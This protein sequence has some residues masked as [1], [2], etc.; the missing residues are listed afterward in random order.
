MCVA[1]KR[2]TADDG[3]MRDRPLLLHGLS[4]PYRA[5]TGLNLM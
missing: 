3:R 5:G 1:R 2:A 4:V